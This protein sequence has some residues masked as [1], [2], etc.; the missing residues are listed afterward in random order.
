MIP[1]RLAVEKNSVLVIMSLRTQLALVVKGLCGVQGC[2]IRDSVASKGL[3]YLG[4]T[5]QGRKV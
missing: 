4:N 1:K 5:G 3:E 2:G